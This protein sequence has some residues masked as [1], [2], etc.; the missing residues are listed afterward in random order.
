MLGKFQGENSSGCQQ[1]EAEVKNGVAY[2]KHVIAKRWII[3]IS[4]FLYITCD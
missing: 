1:L 3:Y 4:G 2:K